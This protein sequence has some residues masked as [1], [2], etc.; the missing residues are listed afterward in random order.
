MKQRVMK[1]GKCIPIRN[2]GSMRFT[3]HDRFEFLIPN[4]HPFNAIDAAVKGICIAW[5][6]FMANSN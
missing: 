4:S 1:T 3:A 6:I 2:D 5:P